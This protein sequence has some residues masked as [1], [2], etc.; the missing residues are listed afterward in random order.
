MKRTLMILIIIAG[1]LLF[2][3]CPETPL[4][5]AELKDAA[6]GETIAL[7]WDLNYDG[8]PDRNEDGTPKLVLDPKIYT[9]ANQA[10]SIG[11]LVLTGLGAFGVPFVAGIAVFWK[12]HKLGKMIANLVASVQ[13]GRASVEANGAKGSLEIF[14]NALA[15]A[16]NPKT[17]AMVADLKEAAGLPSVSNP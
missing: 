8:V 7:A 14:D 13:A 15:N 3:G 6:T 9:A 2:T 17:A 11:P 4:G 1:P 16:Q 10:D 5:T 12:K